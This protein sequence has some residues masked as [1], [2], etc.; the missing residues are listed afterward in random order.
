MIS[1]DLNQALV[2]VAHRL[3][4]ASLAKLAKALA[5]YVPD[6]AVGQVNI[7]FVSDA[8]IKRL[9]RMYR[10]KDKVTDV[11]SF[12]SGNLATTGQLGDVLIA[13]DQAV[14]QAENGD[15]ELEIA[16]LLVHGILH[17]LGYDHE[18]PIDAEEM[19]PLQD[20]IVARIL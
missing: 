18:L 12:E 2:P 8:E 13:Y 5:E 19:F 20:K 9:N 3:S 16:D 11:L 1:F 10:S 14:R 17:L 7:S 6:Q 4:K 15:L